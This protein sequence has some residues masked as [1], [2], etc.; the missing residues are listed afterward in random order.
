MRRFFG[1]TVP[2]LA[3][4]LIASNV[5]L[6]QGQGQGGRGGRGGFG[7]FGGGGQMPVAF[8]LAS[9]QVQKDLK[10]TD[11]QTAKI[12]E[13]GEAARPPRGGGGGANFRE[14]TE[15]QRKAFFEDLRKKGEE[16]SKKVTDLLTAE[17][18][19]RVKQIQLWMQGARA[20]TEN[21]DVAKELS[22][23]D[24]QKAAVKTIL[25][26]SGKKS[27]ELR[28]GRRNASDEERKKIDDQLTAIRTETETESLAQLTADQ[29]AKFDALKGPKFEV[30]RSQFGFGGPGGGRGRA[31]RPGGNN[32]NN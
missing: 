25:E 1:M 14:M 18:N 22:L 26:E 24:D 8:L 29:K 9:P 28:T 30:D 7:G 3:L 13:I 21:A 27:Q 16:A 31:G 2:V 23:T 4:C 15:E 6:A 20:L 10:L 5:A 11:E 32:N 17:Q 19:A 12:K